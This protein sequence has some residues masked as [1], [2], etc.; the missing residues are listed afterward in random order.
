MPFYI[1]VLILLRCFRQHRVCVTNVEVL[2][3]NYIPAYTAYFLD[4][5]ANTY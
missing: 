5:K 4:A 1:V 3:R 2:G